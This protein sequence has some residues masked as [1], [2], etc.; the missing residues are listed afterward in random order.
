MAGK[1]HKVWK[2]HKRQLE[3]VYLDCSAPL[4]VIL[5]QPTNWL[6]NETD[7]S[8]FCSYKTVDYKHVQHPTGWCT[9]LSP[10]Y[11]KIAHSLAESVYPICK[12]DK[13]RF[14][15]EDL[16]MDRYICMACYTIYTGQYMN[17]MK[18]TEKLADF[19]CIQCGDVL[20]AHTS[21]NLCTNCYLLEQA[22]Y[23]MPAPS[24][25]KEQLNDPITIE[26]VKEEYEKI[27]AHVSHNQL[28]LSQP[29]PK[30]KEQVTPVESTPQSILCV[31]GKYHGKYIS[32]GNSCP[33]D[34]LPYTY[35][36]F[37]LVYVFKPIYSEIVLEPQNEDSG[38]V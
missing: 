3:D 28:P 7:P 17:I 33:K 26:K 15:Y 14:Y 23:V 19:A 10:N 5:P 11:W 22:K 12:C 4:R 37:G 36:I 29:K 8:N 18:K 25:M 38:L 9:F 2:E 24:Y 31:G 30:P 20:S 6:V 1:L 34:Y 27:K 21:H 16:A 13:S 35:E 32:L